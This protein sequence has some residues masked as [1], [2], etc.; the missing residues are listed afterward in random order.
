MATISLKMGEDLHSALYSI[1]THLVEHYL[2]KNDTEADEYGLKLHYYAQSIAGRNS[3]QILSDPVV[4][5]YFFNTKYLVN[6]TEKEYVTKFGRMRSSF[7]K[8]LR[9]EPEVEW[10]RDYVQ[11][12]LSTYQFSFLVV[13]VL[14]H[15]ADLLKSP[16]ALI[17]LFTLASSVDV[18][19]SCGSA[20]TEATQ[21]FLDS[22]A[23]SQRKR[24]IQN[25]AILACI[26]DFYE[27]TMFRFVHICF[28]HLAQNL[29]DC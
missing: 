3:P 5:D 13:W 2:G 26:F 8:A 11:W 6:A 20:L 15:L 29:I 18:R 24:A 14:L 28:W 16:K 9:T 10:E 27:D 23:G 25:G 7:P 19:N 12:D 1:Y 4:S 21:H 17:Q 22:A